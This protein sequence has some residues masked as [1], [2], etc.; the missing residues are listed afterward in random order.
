MSLTQHYSNHQTESQLYKREHLKTHLERLPSLSLLPGLL[1]LG[2]PHRLLILPLPHST[3][4]L[5][6][7]QDVQRRKFLQLGIFLPFRRLS[8][9]LVRFAPPGED[10]DIKRFKEEDHFVDGARSGGT[11]FLLSVQKE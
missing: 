6:R 9:H 1:H 7:Q 11:V 10:S 5:E 8:D 4:I 2:P 3:I